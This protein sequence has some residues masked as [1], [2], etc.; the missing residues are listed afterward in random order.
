MRR[1]ILLVVS[2]A[3]FVLSWNAT[4]RAQEKTA[5][6]A[7]YFPAEDLVVYG[8]FD[9]IDAHGDAWKKTATYKIMT[10]TRTGAM[11]ESLA[12]QI[13]DAVMSSV[14]KGEKGPSA[15]DVKVLARHL[16]RSGFAFGVNRHPGQPKPFS[17]GLVVRGAGRADVRAAFSKQIDAL[18]SGM[19]TEAVT[20]AG[21]RRVMMVTRKGGPG[22]AW[23]SEGDDL[24]FGLIQPASVNVDAMVDALE[25]KI[26]SAVQDPARAALAKT[27]DGFEPVALAYFDMAALPELPPKAA[28]LGLDRVKRVDYRWGFQG[29][30]LMT[31]TRLI[32]PAPRSGALA[33]LDQP[34]FTAKTLPPVASGVQ[35]LTVY[36]FDPDRFFRLFTSL[37]VASDPN[38]KKQVDSG[39]SAFQQVTGLKLREDVL[40]H[41]GPKV[42]VS[43]VP[44]RGNL[45]TNAL[46][47]FA[48]GMVHVPRTTVLIE[49]RDPGAFAKSFD[50]LIAKAN[51]MLRSQVP[52]G[53]K[54]DSIGFLPLKGQP[55]GYVVSF[56]PETL[57]LPAGM[58]PTLILG[59]KYLV[60]GT[61]PEVAR[62]AMAIEGG[63]SAVDGT[64][65]EALGHLPKDM[66]FVTVSDTR[67]SLLP[68]VVANL[69]GLISL[70]SASRNSGGPL[71]AMVPRMMG[72]PAPGGPGRPGFS[73]H[74]DPDS[75]PS[76]DDLRPFL[77][78]STQSFTADD[79][80]FSFVTRESFPGL[81]P[82]AAIPVAA[83]M[84]LPAATAARVS[85]RRSQS[86]NNL[87]QIGLAMHN[88]V[89]TND[90]IPGPIRDKD[91][92]PLLSWRVQV[93]PFIEQQALF[94]EFRMDEPW[95]SPHNKT[96][97]ERMPSVYAV[98]GSD[99][100]PGKTFY[101]SFSGNRT[102]FDPAKT[103][104]KF[105][106][107][108]DGLSNT[109]AVVEAREAVEWT[110]PDNEIPF[111]DKAKD[112]AEILAQLGGHFAGGFDA[113]LLDGSVRFIKE[114]ISPIVLK[115]LIT[116]DAGEI[117][118]GDAF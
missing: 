25:G 59:K 83:A 33:M 73:I 103:S 39:E 54:A 42:S 17:V 75:I 41:L 79:Q 117:V 53:G 7:R 6:L 113:L 101:R 46:M 49:I 74:I 116:R 102:L 9:G 55:G 14:P 22:F 65:A 23:W 61:T 100:E 109:L 62:K 56:P 48:S 32:A 78:P 63:A 16:V 91:G 51:Q 47:G 3:A 92:K 70:V 52:P 8:E 29:D 60:V 20:K 27:T 11:L 105:A 106:D 118:S 10:E 94:N 12:G 38:A 15:E 35:G 114:T 24:A 89:S 2:F 93:L 19:K 67:E 88:F 115:A 96:L 104:V 13:L 72:F 4:A 90:K 31:V 50:T 77:F 37:A 43:T 58:R 34:T 76:P 28:S 36:S 21:D 68:E 110:R 18:G 85:A 1:P 40:A 84:V 45:P 87:K 66:I 108:Q 107:I 95:D 30:A 5:P 71:S 80:G 86:V 57:P 97:I 44:T 99:A 111:D 81:N 82:A 112:A 64:I 26:P 98:P 69:P